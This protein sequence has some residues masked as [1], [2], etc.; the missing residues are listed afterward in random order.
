MGILLSCAYYSL[1]WHN[2]KPPVRMALIQC[3]YIRYPH[4][5]SPES[6]SHSPIHPNAG[7]ID[8]LD[9][10]RP[11]QAVHQL[12]QRF[13]LPLRLDHDVDGRGGWRHLTQE[14]PHMLQL[15]STWSA[16]A[17]T[18]LSFFGLEMWIF[19]GSST[20]TNCDLCQVAAIR[21]HSSA[22][23][24]LGSLSSIWACLMHTSWIFSN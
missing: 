20:G 10:F 24:S 19:G 18:S 12:Q 15:S 6:S 9:S 21:G 1:A 16:S 7:L 3:K 14:W 23:D 8:H 22:A 13:I 4:H 17:R 11:S 2:R 5:D